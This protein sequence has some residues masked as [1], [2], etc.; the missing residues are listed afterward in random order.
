MT[1]EPLPTALVTSTVVP[2]IKPV[3]ILPAAE[4]NDNSEL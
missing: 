2:V 3:A 4:D 1:T